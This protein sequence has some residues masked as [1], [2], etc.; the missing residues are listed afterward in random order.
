MVV[1][2]VLGAAQ[3]LGHV[4]PG[5]LDVQAARVGSRSV[6]RLEEAPGLVE[7]GGEAARLV[8]RAG[9][10]RVAVHGVADPGDRDA[11]V[12]RGLQQRRQRVT[13]PVGPHA[14]DEGEPA[15]LAAGVESIG[16]R[17]DVGRRRRRAELDADGVA[18]AGEEVHVGA[19]ELPG[20]LP[21]P[22]EVGGAVVGVPGPGVDAG[23]RALVVEEQ[24]LVGGVE[25]H[26]ADRVEVHAR[27]SHEPHSAVDLGGQHLVAGV[28]GV[29]HEALVPLVDAPQVRETAVGEGPDEVQG[30]G[31][32]VVG[33]QQ[34]VWVRDARFRGE[35]VAVDGV[36]TER[37]QLDAVAHLGVRRARL[38]VLAR[39]A[40][41]LDD[42]EG[43]PVGEHHGHL[44]DRLYLAPDVVR[45][46]RGE[47]LG[48]VAALQDERLA[49]SGGRHE[50]LQS[51]G[52]AGEHERRGG[53]ELVHGAPERLRVGPVRLLHP[54]KVTP[55]VELRLQR[56]IRLHS[57]SSRC[58][59]HLSDSNR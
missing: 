51:V 45:G 14:R 48:A 50:F 26:G 18:H 59:S 57:A 29:P 23:Q 44:Q 27:R 13:D 8:A 6:V 49:P 40:P 28:G 30:G 2:E 47:G 37:R 17:A 41:H 24:R 42:G 10:D 21:D 5:E 12:P 3:H 46:V 35:L 36:A 39:H 38:G 33:A 56:G 16:E 43:R 34:P 11:V 31:R 19:V 54:G 20:P 22:E 15:L 53:R 55:M 58:S 52:L 4:V 32:G 1:I 7:H 9:H 25:L